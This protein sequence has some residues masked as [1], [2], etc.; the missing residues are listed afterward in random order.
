MFANR[1]Q[2]DLRTA[3]PNHL[4][5]ME[6]ECHSAVNPG[7]HEMVVEL[8]RSR[9]VKAFLPESKMMEKMNGPCMKLRSSIILHNCRSPLPHFHLPIAHAKLAHLPDSMAKLPGNKLIEHIRFQR[10]GSMLHPH[11]YHF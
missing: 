6:I 11:F 4:K 2:I 9:F 8:N 1:R 3:G 7:T 10:E 5:T